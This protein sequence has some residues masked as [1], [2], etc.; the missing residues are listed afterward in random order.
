MDV[1]AVHGDEHIEGFAEEVATAHTGIEHSEAGEIEGRRGIQC[2]WFHIVFPVSW[3]GAIRVDFMVAASQAVLQQPLDHVGFGEEFG[4]GSYL[5]SSHG[6]TPT[7]KFGVDT[8]FG[9]FLVELVGPADRVRVCEG[10]IRFGKDKAWHSSANTC[11]AAYQ[12]GCTGAKCGGWIIEREEAGKRGRLGFAGIL[13]HCPA[14]TIITRGAAWIA[15]AQDE[16]GLGRTIVIGICGKRFVDQ[17][18]CF[19]RTPCEQAVDPG[20]GSAFYDLHASTGTPFPGD[21]FELGRDD[22]MRLTLA[23]SW[24]CQ[25]IKWD[26]SSIE[27]DTQPL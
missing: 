12:G 9:L 6:L 1:F 22:T 16:E 14:S 18:A 2:V 13:K 24:D 15:L 25:G 10:G 23:G 19:H 4:R 7:A 26:K 21:I 3:Q 8:R 11:H 17:P 5:S 20:V 27:R